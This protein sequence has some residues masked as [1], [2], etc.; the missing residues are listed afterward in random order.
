MKR[1]PLKR[2]TPLRKVS[3]KQARIQRARR[4]I[5]RDMERDGAV[6]CA[7]RW[8]RCENLASDLHELLPRGR[9]GDATLS[10]NIIPVCRKCHDMLHL[11]VE[12]AE[13]EGWL[14]KSNQ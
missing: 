5:A 8:E 3:T 14:K 2:R 13:S 10:E 9:G 1:T 12:R 6:L 11:H 7:V 4:K